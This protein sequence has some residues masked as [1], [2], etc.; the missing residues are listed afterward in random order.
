[1]YNNGNA[2]VKTLY[3]DDTVAHKVH[4][5]FYCSPS[6]CRPCK[7]IVISASAQSFDL[8]LCH[9]AVGEYS[10]RFAGHGRCHHGDLGA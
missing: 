5:S 7:T 10:L 9:L 6:V 2:G 8:T 1:M 3:D 4:D